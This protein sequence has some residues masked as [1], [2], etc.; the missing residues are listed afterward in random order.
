MPTQ[1]D[2]AQRPGLAIAVLCAGGLSAAL[3]QTMVIPIQ[4]E[5]PQLLSTSASNASWV[6]TITLLAAAVTMPVAGRIADMIGK[7][8]VLVASAALLTIGSVVCAISDS[9]VPVLAGRALQGLAMGFIPVGISFIRQFAPPEMA[10]TGVATMS[11]TLGVGGAIGLPLAA[12]IADSGDW[13]TLFWVAAGLSAVITALTWFAV[14][15]VHDAHDGRLDVV[16]T[17]GLAIGLS[18]FLVGVS[19][20]STWGWDSGRTWGAIV[21]GIVVLLAWGAFELR[22]AE[23]LV[24]L[25]TT[26]SPAVLMTNLAAVAVGFGM[27]AQSIVV[28]Q[29]LQLPEMTGFGLGQSILAAGLWMAPAGLMMLV[30]AP[31]SS[32]LMKS[33]GAKKTLMIGAAVLGAGYLVALVMMAAPWQLLVA[34]CVASAG[35]GIG[36]AAMPTLILDSVPAHEAGS[37]VGVNGLM[38]SAGTTLAAA[39]MATLLTSST[40]DLGG[41][42]VPTES[43]FRWCFVVGAIAAFVGVAIASMVPVVA[44]RTDAIGADLDETADAAV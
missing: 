18:S 10:S 4:S 39:V 41:F 5:L 40:V 31:V 43:A 42:A 20:G 35:V 37:A 25:R 33:I 27:M 9:L 19:K 44:R 3:T 16:G 2:A 38:R 34:S 22:Q 24:D 21:L 1:T 11:A 28:P 30:F 7:Q 14:P 12:W 32:G 13:H 26:A 23:P 8:R 6:I 15:H 17:I 36:Y 29:L